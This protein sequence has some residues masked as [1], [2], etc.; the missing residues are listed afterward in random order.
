MG[1]FVWVGR[2]AMAWGPH[3]HQEKADNEQNSSKII[4]MAQF[5]F[6]VTKV[7]RA[8]QQTRNYHIRQHGLHLAFKSLFMGAFLKMAFCM[9]GGFLK[10]FGGC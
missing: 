8:K 10:T 9:L 4:D 6:H 5:Q 2:A 1:L 7:I 3:V